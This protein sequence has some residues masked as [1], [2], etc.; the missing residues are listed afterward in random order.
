MASS[1]S[2]DNIE[3]ALDCLRRDGCVFLLVVGRPGEKVT[4]LNSRNR[5]NVDRDPVE[6]LRESVNEHLDKIW[7]LPDDD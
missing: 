3:D 4:R 7:C 5:G 2:L 1:G 6:H